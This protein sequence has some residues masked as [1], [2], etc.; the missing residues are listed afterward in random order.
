M[1]RILLTGGLTNLPVCDG[2]WILL[3]APGQTPTFPPRELKLPLQPPSLSSPF[4]C[5]HLLPANSKASL[6]FTS[7]YQVHHDSRPQTQMTSITSEYWWRNG[8]SMSDSHSVTP[9]SLPSQLSSAPHPV[10]SPPE[11]DL[12]FPEHY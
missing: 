8:G 3:S 5:L 4:W 11:P 2:L 7:L 12:I 9:P 1:L 10:P 6:P